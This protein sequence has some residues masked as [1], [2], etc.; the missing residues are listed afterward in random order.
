[1][2]KKE[3]KI[4]PE[5]LKELIKLSGYELT[6]ISNK[7]SISLSRL[8]EGRITLSQ[9]KKLAGI[10]KRPIAAFFSDEIPS[11][12]VIPDYRLNREKRIN[13]EVLLAK[14]KLTYL[15][16]KLKELGAKKTTIPSFEGLLSPYQLAKRFRD[17]L[18]VKVKKNQNP[19]D[20][21]EHYKHILEDKLS[22]VILEYP[23][24]PKRSKGSDDVRA[25]SIYSD[26]SGIVLNENDHPSVKLFSLFHEVAH[27]IRKSSGICS[28]EFEVEKEF[29][30]ESFCNKFA[31]EF[32]VPVEDMREE[33]TNYSISDNTISEIVNN[34]SKTY[35]VS[36]QVILLRLL[37]LEYL[38]SEKY[39]LFKKQ[40][41]EKGL[42]KQFGRRIW[43]KVFKNQVGNLTIKETK[44]ALLE[45]KISFYEALNILDVKTKYAEKFLYE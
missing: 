12:P 32:L 17:Y 35:G 9:L 33:L 27:L 36:K 4:R 22:V 7:A 8:E 6:E 25:F 15:L 19:S 29:E 3:L 40:L 45:N 16:E 28:L 5:V 44:R 38:Q 31:A 18:E 13:P 2:I 43:E 20:L 30:E 11:L 24:K 41:E 26:I 1:M 10:L 39:Y 23:L 37:Y 34:L 21:L 42:E 14:R